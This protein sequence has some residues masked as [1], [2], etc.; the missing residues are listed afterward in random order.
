MVIAA[1]EFNHVGTPAELEAYE[2]AVPKA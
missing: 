2:Q 1:D